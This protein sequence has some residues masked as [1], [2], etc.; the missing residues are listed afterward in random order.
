[1][2]PTPLEIPVAPKVK[3]TLGQPDVDEIVATPA[4]GVP[5]HEPQLKLNL[6]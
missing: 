4:L 6:T 3:L 1:V 2:I 5:L